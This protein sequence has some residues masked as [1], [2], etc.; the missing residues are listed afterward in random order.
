M[1]DIPST[2]LELIKNKPKHY[3]K[4]VKSNPE[5]RNWVLEN[6]LVQSD[7]YAE[8]IY[9]AIHQV[10]N[11]CQEGNI[12]KFGSFDAGYIGCGPAATCA[13]TA[14]VLSESVKKTKS[15]ISKEQQDSIN[16]KRKNTNLK[17]YGVECSAQSR[18]VRQKLQDYYADPERV[19]A[20][21]A[22][23][24][25][26]YIDKYGVENCRHLPE[27]EEKRLATIMARYGVTNI[28]Q[29]PSTKAKLQARTAEY[30]LNGHLLKKGYERF[31]NYINE[32]YNFTL[33]T[34]LDLYE[35]IR[36]RD[37]QE[38][39]F[40]CNQCQTRVVKKF[41]HGRGIS[42]EICNPPCPKF[43]SNEEQAIFDFIT[44]DLGI[45]NGRQGD[46][47]LINPY[48][49]DMVFPDQK[50]AIEYCGLYWHSELSSGKGQ[51]YHHDKMILSNKAGYRLV[52]IFSD[53]WNTKQEIVKSKLSNIFGRTQNKYYARKCSLRTVSAAD[54]RDFLNRHHLQGASI[55]K[56]NLGLYNEQ[57]R[58]VALMTFSNGR[59]ALNTKSTPDEYELVRFVTDGSSVVGGA[60]KL[61]KAFVRLYKPTKITSY[62]DLRW[63]EGNV[64]ET[65]GFIKNSAP[66]IGYWYVDE[67]SNREH[68]YNFTKGQL[69]AAGGDPTKTEWQIMQDLGYDRVWDCGHQKYL[70][71]VSR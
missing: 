34:S 30:K 51:R 33:R 32:K 23:I 20:T 3:S 53:E 36:Q 68:R 19:A 56:I 67:Y 11:V 40:E 57:N 25:K 47:K 58:L 38:M 52:T 54:S 31:C 64:Y 71:E 12:R 4:I 21:L 49:L 37:V 15:L 10:T 42:C 29:I 6:S 41:Y 55:A 27:V 69:V 46:K 13:C 2:I 28:A 8:L 60:S 63:S 14:K 66:T 62:A 45:K 17:K 5:L 1:S 18:E 35:G 43:T 22:K 24:K 26:T 7:Q 9:S 61:L 65:I 59:K 16:Q 70:M 48:E 44:V 50:I 39:E